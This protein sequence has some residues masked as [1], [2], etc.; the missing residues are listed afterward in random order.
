MFYS[1]Q[2]EDER[3][4]YKKYLQLTGALSSLFSDSSVP[5]LYYRAAE[6]L[7]CLAFNADNLS[8][9]DVSADAKK[10]TTGIGLKTFIHGTGRSLQKIAEFNAISHQLRGKKT[11]EVIEK[12]V[13]SRN[14]RIQSTITLFG[15]NNMIYH[16]VTRK[17][18]INSL[19]ECGMDEIDLSNINITAENHNSIK[20]T[21]NKNEYSFNKSKSTLFK[22]FNFDIPLEQVDIEIIQNPFDSLSCLFE[23]STLS[24]EHV[25][26]KVVYLPL[27]APSSEEMQPA[28]KSGLNQWN[29]G[30]RERNANEVYIPIPAW[31]HRVFPGFFPDN[32]DFVFELEL[33]NGDVLKSKLC[34]Q[35]GKGLMSNPNSE[36]G[37]WLLRDVLQ[38]PEDVL[39]SREI[40]DLANIDSAVV[41]KI[42]DNY[43]KINFASVG[44]YERFKEM[45]GNA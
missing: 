37:R 33:P 39:V 13:K 36:L 40:L 41:E 22:R 32:N 27:Y 12:L 1:A 18:G 6:N 5:Y 11:D 20:F 7:F 44:R 21:D 34:Q 19:F 10:D 3:E 28:T 25:S 23:K 26:K 17:E 45:Y 42:E 15:L 38:L 35:G 4:V 43:F 14:L 31:V 30:G 2:P 9:S 16:C 29:A 24:I 8:R